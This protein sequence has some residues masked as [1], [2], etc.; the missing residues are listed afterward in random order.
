MHNFKVRDKGEQAG[1]GE[2]VIA[3]V[4]DFRVGGDASVLVVPSPPYPSMCP[5]ITPAMVVQ[6][7]LDHVDVV[8][9]CV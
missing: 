8:G 3:S 2:H 7:V 1:I 9:V 5:Q 6:E 4:G